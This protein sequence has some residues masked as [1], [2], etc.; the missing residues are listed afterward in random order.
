MLDKYHGLDVFFPLFFVYVN[1]Y[2][3]IVGTKLFD[4]TQDFCIY[5]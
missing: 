5:T 3:N 4:G 2:G 1:F